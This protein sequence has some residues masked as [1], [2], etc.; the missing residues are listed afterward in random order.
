MLMSKQTR[1]SGKCP[2]T[3]RVS[4]KSVH[5]TICCY[6]C[7]VTKSCLTLCYP[8][9]CHLPGSSATGFPRQEYWSGLPIPSPANLPKPGTEPMDIH[10][11][12]YRWILYCWAARDALLT[13]HFMVKTWMYLHLQWEPVTLSTSCSSQ[14]KQENKFKLSNL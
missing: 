11:L 10:L 2:E 4:T 13:I 8:T 14:C 3:N 6:C 1:Y 9:D 5:V 7:L 12:N